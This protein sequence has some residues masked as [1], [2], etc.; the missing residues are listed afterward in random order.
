MSGC[1]R[2]RL[3]PTKKRLKDRIKQ[4]QAFLHVTLD[5]SENKAN[6]LLLKLEGNLK[7][8]KDLLEQLQESS[9]EDEAKSQWLENEMEEFSILELDGDEAICDLK[10]LLINIAK[11]KQER[12][13]KEEKQR[14]RAHERELQMVKLHSCSITLVRVIE[15]E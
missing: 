5:E 13:E 14:E 9:K 12:T 10:T 1:I 7:S 3:G 15:Q 11:W 4:T 2:Q 8:Y 6:Q